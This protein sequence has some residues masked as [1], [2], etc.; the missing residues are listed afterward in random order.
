MSQLPICLAAFVSLL[1]VPSAPG[2]AGQE[3]AKPAPPAEY[4]KGRGTGAPPA[5]DGVAAAPIEDDKSAATQRLRAAEKGLADKEPRLRAAAIEPFLVH[6]HETYVKR[7]ASLLKDRNDDVAKLAAKAL[8]NQP[9]PAATE[10]LLD[11]ACNEKQLSARSEVCAEAIRAVGRVG[12]GKKGYD[13]LRDT[14]L[15]GDAEV[16]GALCQAFAAAK[17]KRAFS[18]L[19]DQFEAPQPAN[20]N[21]PSNP[22]E[23]YWRA[24]H[25]E[26][27]KYSMHAKKALKE[28]TGEKFAT[29]KEWKA[30]AAGPGKALGFSYKTGQ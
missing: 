28:L 22:P 30:W 16:K 1:A 9:Y 24:R 29:M 27:S 18:F 21:D 20:V 8:A 25:E 4:E 6:R 15:Q 14:F 12:L 17:E 7:L 26:W 5:T 13:R 10:A 2:H 23:S 19:V 3:P 11:F